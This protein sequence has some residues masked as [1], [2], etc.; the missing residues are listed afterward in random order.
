MCA[1]WYRYDEVARY[2]DYFVWKVDRATN[3]LTT[4]LTSL[5][6]NRR[7][8]FS[9]RIER[10]IDSGKILI[11]DSRYQSSPSTVKYA[12]FEMD[13]DGTL[14]TWNDG[15]QF[16]W[17]A[18][19]GLPQNHRNGFIEGPSGTTVYQL[20]PGSGARTTLATLALPYPIHGAHRWDLQTTAAPRIVVQAHGY[21]TPQAE[22]WLY[23]LDGTTWTVTSIACSSLR[24]YNYDL[25]FLP[26]ATHP[27][28]SYCSQDVE[29]AVEL[30]AFRQ[31]RPTPWP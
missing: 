12:V 23:Y 22:S 5:T 30:P 8:Y 6:L 20:Q 26:G 21:Q 9:D 13:L 10:N 19:Y 3:A 29:P 27:V 17:N 28:C 24:C 14:S 15:S 31:T 18:F 1:G 25:V 16:G 7:A 4:L 11:G 2:E